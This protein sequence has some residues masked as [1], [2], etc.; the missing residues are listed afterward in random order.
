MQNQ[1]T[2]WTIAPEIGSKLLSFAFLFLLLLSVVGKQTSNQ[3]PG[4]C[5]HCGM[6]L[7]TNSSAHPR[8]P[9]QP[10]S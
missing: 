7:E 5:R 6:S 8:A 10:T 9:Q 4:Q 2:P 3:L 1:N